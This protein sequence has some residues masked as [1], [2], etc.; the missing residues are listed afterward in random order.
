VAEC[1]VSGVDKAEVLKSIF[2]SST[3]SKFRAVDHSAIDYT[4]HWKNW[5]LLDFLQKNHA[6]PARYFAFDGLYY[7]VGKGGDMLGE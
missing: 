1:A 4:V 3:S 5:D 2:C 6:Q 7:L